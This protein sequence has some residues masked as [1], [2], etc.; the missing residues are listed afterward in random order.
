MGRRY[1][2]KLTHFRSVPMTLT[3][4]LLAASLAL[5]FLGLAQADPAPPAVRAEIDGL[6]KR[7]QTSGCQFNRNGSWYSGD[8]AKTHLLEKLGFLENAD[9]LTST[10]QFIELAAT[11][12]SMSGKPYLVR[13]GGAEPVES[14]KWLNGELKALRAKGAASRPQK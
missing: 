5:A 11:R 14:A 3:R 8:A 6:L 9:T 10:E 4:R 1:A 12:S 2:F 7:L 13:C